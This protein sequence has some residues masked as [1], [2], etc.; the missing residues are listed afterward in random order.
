M[1]RAFKRVATARA[2]KLFPIPASPTSTA[3]RR[4]T[5][6]STRASASPLPTRSAPAPAPATP[7]GETGKVPTRAV[8]TTIL[9]NPRDQ[10]KLAGNRHVWHPRS[11]RRERT[12]VDD[13]RRRAGTSGRVLG[14]ERDDAGPPTLTSAFVLAVALARRWLWPTIRSPRLLR[15]RLEDDDRFHVTVPAFPRKR[16]HPPP[17]RAV[18]RGRR[19]SQRPRRPPATPSRQPHRAPARSKRERSGLRRAH[20]TTARSCP[21]LAAAVDLPPVPAASER[22]RTL[23]LYR[24]IRNATTS[25]VEQHPSRAAGRRYL[26]I[27]GSSW[28]SRPRHHRRPTGLCGSV[29]RP[30]APARPWQQPRWPS[31][32]AELATGV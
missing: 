1:P 2:A 22:Q 13:V 15:G 12:R 5:A 28:P 3:P 32:L 26:G 9:S 14:H 27:T 24:S 29:T 11:R 8:I 7:L 17:R 21:P 19:C 6:S 25:A 16:R 23:S 20:L 30:S 4:R 31:P 10:R 18:R